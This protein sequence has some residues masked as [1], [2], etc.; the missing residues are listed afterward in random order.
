MRSEVNA[1]VETEVVASIAC[2][3]IAVVTAIRIFFGLIFHREESKT[4]V[5]AYMVVKPYSDTNSRLKEE[6]AVGKRFAG[7]TGNVV[8]AIFRNSIKITGFERYEG[9]DFTDDVQIIA[10]G[11]IDGNIK[12]EF[13]APVFYISASFF[14]QFGF[15]V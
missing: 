3:D 4:E 8:F 11:E 14:L 6:T 2:A 7:R 12:I 1:Y 13:E 9:T 5:K 10:C 15:S